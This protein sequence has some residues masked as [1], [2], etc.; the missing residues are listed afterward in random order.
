MP[1]N[2]PKDDADAHDWLQFRGPQTSVTHDATGV[3]FTTERRRGRIAH[4]PLPVVDDDADPA[5][6]SADAVVR[7]VAEVL[8]ESNPLV[9]WGVACE[10]C[11]DVFDSPQAVN[12]HQSAHPGSGTDDAD[13][14]DA[15][16]G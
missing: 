2:Q 8:V 9:C 11:G 14:V 7:S 5:D 6:V 16:G 15:D 1:Q 4:K 10:V 13:G 3:H 12:S